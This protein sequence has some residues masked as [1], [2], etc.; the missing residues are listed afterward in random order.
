M[1]S[2]VNT[3]VSLGERIASLDVLRGVAIL[4]IL[5]MNIVIFAMVNSAYVLPTVYGDLEGANWWT[6]LSLHY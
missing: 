2:T 3:P 4:G 5:L 1:D 6:W